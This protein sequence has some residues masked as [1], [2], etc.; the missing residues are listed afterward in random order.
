MSIT[1][2]VRLNACPGTVSKSSAALLLT[3][4]CPVLALILNALFVLPATILNVSVCPASGLSGSLN[5]RG[6]PT[7]VS[8]ALFSAIEK[9]AGAI[10][11]GLFPHRPTTGRSVPA[12]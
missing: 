9:I 1:R 8:L 6:V 4:I 3:L 2:T 7:F 11:G 12:P 5:V 10:T